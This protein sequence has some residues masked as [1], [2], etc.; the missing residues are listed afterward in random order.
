M[1]RSKGVSIARR[2]PTRNSTAGSRVVASAQREAFA[3]YLET[4]VGASPHTVAAYSR[5]VATFLDWLLETGG[6]DVSTLTLQTLTSFIRHLTETG[7]ATTSVARGLVSVKMFLRYLQLEGVVEKN[8]AELLESP[9]LWKHL[10]TVLSPQNVN[11]LLSEPDPDDRHCYRDRAILQLM[12]AT[13]ARAS[14]VA[15][16]TLTAVSLAGRHVRLFGKG[17]KERVVSLTPPAVLAIETYLAVERPTLVHDP[18]EILF[19]TRTGRPLSR[20]GIWNLVKKYA[21]R[22]G[23]GD[24]V[25]PHTLRHSFATHMLAGG[26]EIRALQELLG[27][28]SIRTT[29]VYTHVDSSRMKSIHAACHPRG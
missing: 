23:C 1:N 6:P 7:K 28:A 24:G 12:Y 16:L 2:K 26:A 29:Q 20:I 21:T 13:G 11:R 18:T 22:I 27:H 3:R 8:A 17:R 9:K 19:L 4:E 10:P 5:D 15:G 25:S 14:E